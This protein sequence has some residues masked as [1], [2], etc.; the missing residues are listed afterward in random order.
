MAKTVHKSQKWGKMAKIALTPHGEKE[1]IMVINSFIVNHKIC[2]I[3]MYEP[4]C[5]A[6]RGV[7]FS[8]FPV[9]RAYVTSLYH[10]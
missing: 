5:T 2:G 3:D 4:V 8:T 1:P 6:K 9:A 10:K 7:F